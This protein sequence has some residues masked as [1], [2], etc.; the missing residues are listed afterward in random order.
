VF[1]SLNCSSAQ[2]GGAVTLQMTDPSGTTTTH[3][4]FSGGAGT[5]TSP[6]SNNPIAMTI[7]TGTTITLTQTAQTAGAATVW[8]EI[9]AA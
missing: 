4:V 9:W 2:T 8:A 7:R 5:G 1:A 3:T 6:V